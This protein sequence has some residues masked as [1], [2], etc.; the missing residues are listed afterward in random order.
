M[1][2]LGVSA[3]IRQ[4]RNQV[5]NQL[6]HITIALGLITALA[7]C[8]GQAAPVYEEVVPASL[9]PGDPIPAPT[10]EVILTIYGDLAAKNAG[11]TLQFDMPTLERLGLVSTPFMIHGSRPES[12][13]LAS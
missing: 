4:R 2:D 5:L 6:I 13:T 1:T 12:L 10:E 7:A 3:R 11:D 9:S 8:S